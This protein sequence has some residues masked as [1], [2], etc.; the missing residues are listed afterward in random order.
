MKV[1]LTHE[2][3]APDFAGGGEYVALETARSLIAEGVTLRVVTTG[4][5]SITDYEGIETIRLPMHRYRM[6]TASEKIADLA[7]DADIIHTFNYHACLPSLRAGRRLGKPVVCMTLG[8]FRDAW[9]EMRGPVAGRLWQRWERYLLTRPFDRTLFLSDYSREQGIALGVRPD[10]AVVNNPGI[11]LPLYQ[12]ADPK[13]DVI[14]FVGILDVRKGIDDVLAVARAVPEARFRV[15]GWGPREKELKAKASVNVEF[16][17]FER[18]EKLRDAF[19][20]ARIFILPS[21]A[22][23]FGIALLEAMASG[24]AI[25]SSIPLHFE[26]EQVRAGDV[27]AM[28]AAVRRL[29]GDRRLTHDMGERNHEQAQAFT[30][31]RHARKLIDIYEELL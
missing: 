25:I 11:E 31:Q 19:N 24:C 22:E 17:A 29:W 4:D 10:R 27:P 20:R 3:F 2:Q 12:P 7:V 1:L 16:V 6:I 13:E 14:L 18:G 30:W 26:G 9:R 28:T 5:P 23:T 8:L 15:M 21:Y